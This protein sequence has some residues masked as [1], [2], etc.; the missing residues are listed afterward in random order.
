[1]LVTVKNAGTYVNKLHIGTLKTSNGSNKLGAN[2]TVVVRES[3][4][5]GPRLL[6]SFSPTTI[7]NDGISTLTITHSNPDPSA[8]KLK[9]PLYDYMPKGMVV[10]GDASNT[11]GGKVKAKRGTS[12]VTL[13]GGAIPAN[14]SCKVTVRVTA[15]CDNYFNNLPAGALQ[16]SNGSNQEPSGASLTVTPD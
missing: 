1:V 5:A 3:A 6:K 15:P 2:A 14:G 16:T 7:K 8:A 13:T 10:Y 4:G 9:A 12:I 11:C